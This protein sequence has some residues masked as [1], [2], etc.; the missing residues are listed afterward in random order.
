MTDE[1]KTL[2]QGKFLS[3]VARGRWEF[4]TRNTSKPA[5]AIVAVTS[6]ETVILV[7]QFRPPVNSAV[8]ELPAGL[9]GDIA[10]AEDEP[11][12]EAA[13]RELLEETG[14]V[15]SRWAQVAEGFSSA[16]MTDES[17]VVFL[18][19]G[20]TKVGAG[21]GVDSEDIRLHEVPL[22]GVV[23]WLANQRLPSDLKLLGAVYAAKL[24]R[25]SH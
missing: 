25:E 15:A 24:H 17:T 23:E 11:L 21:G 9:A 16:G 2:W 18:A 4:A 6:D 3:M 19:E 5:V 14:Y 20:L 7:E 8:I 13:K 22:N 1:I 12:V 10:G